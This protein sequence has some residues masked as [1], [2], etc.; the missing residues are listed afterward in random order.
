MFILS[1]PNDVEDIILSYSPISENALM[2][3]L[4]YDQFFQFGNMVL[5]YDCHE[6]TILVDPVEKCQTLTFDELNE[7]L[8]SN[9]S[10][11]F[12]HL[13]VLITNTIK[14]QTYLYS[15]LKYLPQEKNLEI[16]DHF[17]TDLNCP[18]HELLTCIFG[19]MTPTGNTACD[20]QTL[21]LNKKKLRNVKW[22][23]GIALFLN[24]LILHVS[25]FSNNTASSRPNKKRKNLF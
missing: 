14:A 8:L 5:T 2:S 4:K 11:F 21:I 1:L 13:N 7:A 20:L 16:C 22:R 3:I 19:S 18:W 15:P 12:V 23:L 25:M 9:L 24:I 17:C 10:P 6:F